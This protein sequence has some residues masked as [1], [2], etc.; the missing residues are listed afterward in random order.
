MSEKLL[1]N[2]E[3]KK[4][5]ESYLRPRTKIKF[6][7]NKDLNKKV[8]V[9]KLSENNLRG[10]NYIH[11]TQRKFYMTSMAFTIMKRLRN[12]VIF[13]LTISVLHGRGSEFK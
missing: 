11:R 5:M 3:K 6:S 4:H 12:L 10:E 13:K 2:M 8:K 9:V 7:W 1:S